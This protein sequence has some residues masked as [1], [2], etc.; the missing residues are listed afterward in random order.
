MKLSA[1]Y[2]IADVLTGAVQ[3]LAG[4]CRIGDAARSIALKIVDG[5]RNIHTFPVQLIR[6]NIQILP[7]G[8]PIA[9]R[10]DLYGGK[11]PGVL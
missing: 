2:K 11:Q 6:T 5:K 9:V 8:D 3:Q 10:L 7:P 4:P 1:F